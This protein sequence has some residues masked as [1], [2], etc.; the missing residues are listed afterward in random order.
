MRACAKAGTVRK[1][2]ESEEKSVYAKRDSNEQVRREHGRA[3]AGANAATRT[4]EAEPPAA[5][6]SRGFQKSRGGEY[7]NREEGESYK[8]SAHKE[9]RISTSCC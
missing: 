5:A 3:R 8:N 7:L 4:A 6:K 9:V 1:R 2:K